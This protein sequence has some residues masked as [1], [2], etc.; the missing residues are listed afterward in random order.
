MIDPRTV[1]IILLKIVGFIVVLIILT[2][3]ALMLKPAASSSSSGTANGQSGN[4]SN[5]NAQVES[6]PEKIVITNSDGTIT[7]VPNPAIDEPETGNVDTRPVPTPP[8]A[9]STM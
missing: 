7:V 5:G 9:L 1:G 3:I 8:P 4:S 2:V 6:P